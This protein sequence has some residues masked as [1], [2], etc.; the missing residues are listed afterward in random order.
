MRF[1]PPQPDL[2]RIL[3]EQRLQ[4]PSQ[5]AV[6]GRRAR[7]GPIA[8]VRQLR[9]PDA[10]RQRAPLRLVL[11]G[12]GKHRAVGAAIEPAGGRGL[13]HEADYRRCDP[14]PSCTSRRLIATA[15]I[16]SYEAVASRQVAEEA[17]DLLAAARPAPGHRRRCRPPARCRRG[18]RPPTRSG[19][20]RGA[21]RCRLSAER[22]VR[23]SAGGLAS[24]ISLS[25]VVSLSRRAPGR[26]SGRRPP[27]PSRS[28]SPASASASFHIAK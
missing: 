16:A 25:A 3:P 9:P 6:V 20:G 11:A 26:R 15:P 19:A 10:L 23:G 18:Q 13:L 28:A 2:R 1:Q 4:H 22:C 12:D 24:T 17:G 27:M 5:P 21:R 7:R 14:P 8:R